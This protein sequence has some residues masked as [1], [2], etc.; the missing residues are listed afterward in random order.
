MGENEDAERHVRK[1]SRRN[2]YEVKGTMAKRRSHSV[3]WMGIS[4]YNR[5]R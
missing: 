1:G 4:S 3:T 2:L 5:G